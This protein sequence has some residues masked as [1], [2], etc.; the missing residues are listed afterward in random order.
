MSQKKSD[1]IYDIGLH[2]AEDTEF[3]LEKGFEV[4]AFEADPVLAE[5]CRRK[6]S[7]QIADQRLVV[8]EGAIVDPATCGT[9]STVKFYRNETDTVWGT[10]FHEWAERNSDTFGSKSTV[11][12]VPAVNLG[13]CLR[14]YGVPH[15][16]KIDIEGADTLCLR[17]LLDSPVLPDYVSIEGEKLD[18]RKLGEEFELLERL[19]Y[20]R[21]KAVQQANIPTQFPPRPSLEG[22]YVD[23]P[24]PEGSSGLFG[25][26]LPGRWKTRRE[27]L[28]QYRW[29]FLLYRLFGD[30][31]VLRNSWIGI[32][33][34]W[35]LAKLLRQPVPGWFDTHARHSSLNGG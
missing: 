9:A 30:Y 8:V 4:I 1:L 33:F 25:R 23:R 31:G 6:F 7:A 2:Q 11:I 34:R 20:S 16:M 35:G 19:G 5:Q 21:F 26:E 10:I 15:Y 29:I 22:Q 24:F 12:E 17:A 13:E 27:V 28:R 18:F 14:R 32:R 3:Y